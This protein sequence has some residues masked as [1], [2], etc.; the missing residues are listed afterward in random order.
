MRLRRAMVIEGRRRPCGEV[1]RVPLGRL[2]VAATWVRQGVA[3]PADADTMLALQL[4]EAC[5]AL[6]A[7]PVPLP[8]DKGA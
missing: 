2:R 7:A 6:D 1:V 8:D 3:R 5:K 4:F